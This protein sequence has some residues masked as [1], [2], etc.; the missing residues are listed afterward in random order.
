MG[1][2]E[3]PYNLAFKYTPASTYFLQ[4]LGNVNTFPHMGLVGFTGPRVLPNENLKAAKSKVHSK[5]ELIYVSSVERFVW[6]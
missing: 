3:D 1:S 2:D 6:I 5:S 4:Y